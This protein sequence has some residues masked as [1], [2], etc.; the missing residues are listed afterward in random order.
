MR[1]ILIA[2]A[3]AFL[4][5]KANSQG[6]YQPVN[7]TAYGTNNLRGVFR[8][9]LL[10][11]SGCGVPGFMSL[12]SVDSSRSALYADTCGNKMYYY[13]PRTRQWLQSDISS[14]AWDSISGKPVNFSTTYALSNDVRDSIQNRVPYENATRSVSLGNYR[15]NA[16]G[17]L[18]DTLYAR[19]SGGGYLATNSGSVIASF[20]AGGSTEI[21]FHGFAGYNANRGSSYTARS[22][23]DKNYVDSVQE[24]NNKIVFAKFSQLWTK[25]DYREDSILTLGLY[26]NSIFNRLYGAEMA[27]TSNTA[28][29]PPYAYRQNIGKTL[30]DSL[31]FSGSDLTYF[32]AYNKTGFTGQPTASIPP[33]SS[34]ISLSGTWNDYNNN[35]FEYY[36]STSTAGSSI[37]YDIGSGFKFADIIVIREST[38]A[39]SVTVEVSVNGGAFVSPATAGLTG[40]A[41]FST[42]KPLPVLVTGDIQRQ[43]HVKYRGLNPANTYSFRL[44][45]TGTGTFKV[46]GIEAWER[47]SLRVITM[48][49]GGNTSKILWSKWDNDVNSPNLPL[50]GLFIEIPELNN[51]GSVSEPTQAQRNEDILYTDSMMKAIVLQNLPAFAVIPHASLVEPSW[52]FKWIQDA[53]TSA[54]K[55]GIETIDMYNLWKIN[56][57]QATG[58]SDGTHLNNAGVYYYANPFIAAVRSTAPYNLYDPNVKYQIDKI[59][60][61]YIQKNPTATQSGGFKVETGYIGSNTTSPLQVE[62]VG[63]DLTNASVQI[64][65]GAH[66]WYVGQAT[67]AGD[68]SIGEQANLGLETIFRLKRGGGL[69]LGV[70]T[71]TANLHL[72]GGTATAGTAPLKINSGTNMTIP[73]SGAIEYDGSHFYGTVSTPARYR[74][75]QLNDTLGARN[76]LISDAT[77]TNRI[78]ASNLKVV[79]NRLLVANAID[80]SVSTI[81]NEGILR[82]SNLI[83]KS[84]LG[85]AISLLQNRFNATNMYGFGTETGAM[86]Y[87][88][89]TFHRFYVN[90]NANGGTSDIVEISANGAEVNGLLQVNGT[91]RLT[92]RI[93]GTSLTLNKDSVLTMGTTSQFGIAIDTITGAIVKTTR[94]RFASLILNKDSVPIT[95]TNT[96]ILT[97]DT[98]TGVIQRSTVTSGIYL[99]TATNVSNTSAI[100]V[101]TAQYMRVGNVVTVSGRI[102]FTNTLTSP[103]QISLTLPFATVVSSERNVAG[104][105][106]ENI[107]EKVGIIRGRTGTNDALLEINGLNTSTYTVY[108]TYTYRI[109]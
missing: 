9:A 77:G 21:D 4:L 54:A 12:Y 76:I 85:D 30:Y 56:N 89:P 88:S 83:A 6:I 55:Y 35:D 65:T 25:V 48:G 108:Y 97:I 82:T 78:V 34:F 59:Y 52:Y 109:L 51:A 87:K 84:T 1:K 44:T 73:E 19:G 103:S 64:T 18:G 33:N 7:P 27:A 43:F 81:Q 15:L 3:L 69:G 8:T 86:Y 101:D 57:Y 14:V 104:T 17:L 2:L 105:A 32:P 26:G 62:R 38:G 80:D 28:N 94:G 47:K 63:S 41:T 98:S 91:Q 11:P 23:T 31:Q 5:G 70:P 45:N 90:S 95:T 13:N 53:R 92:S 60:A 66:S 20:G 67:G 61:S 71:I 93:F 49:G 46:W 102:A 75:A 10:I 107:A 36:K 99:P 100:T 68:F 22:F 96:Q 16:R 50:D 58:L 39:S 40:D 42:I 79:S 72:K 24:I 29:A 106:N 37:I 74:F